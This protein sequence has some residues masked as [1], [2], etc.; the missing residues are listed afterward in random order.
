MLPPEL[1]PLLRFTLDPAASVVRS[2]RRKSKLTVPPTAPLG[3]KRSRSLGASRRALLVLMPLR[4][5]QVP[6]LLVETSQLPMSVPL[7]SSL[8]PTRAAPRAGAPLSGS[9]PLATSALTST[10]ALLG[11]APAMV[12][13]SIAGVTNGQLGASFTAVTLMLAVLL[14]LE[15]AVLPPVSEVFTRLPAVPLLWSQ[16]R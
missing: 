2:H 1:L 3:A 15:K 16:A 4:A 11:S 9:E 6:P 14:A 5:V 13:R 7:T 8:R 12:P 10:P